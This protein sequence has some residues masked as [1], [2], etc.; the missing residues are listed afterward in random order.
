[1][2]QTFHAH[3]YFSADEITLASQVRENII[4]ALPQLS[5]AGPLIPI[6]V[7]PHTKP[8]F[9]MHIP[10]SIKNY[11]L[12]CI[13]SLREGLSVLVHPVQLDE[14]DAH[15]DSAVWLGTKLPLKLDVLK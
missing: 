5:Y 2:M 15:T 7:G 12:A 14:L 11:A 4:Q 6:P 13:D 3:I 1:M 9:E 10:A 8:M